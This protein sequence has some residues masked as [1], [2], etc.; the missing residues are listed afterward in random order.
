LQAAYEL[1]TYEKAKK[2][3]GT[4]RKELRLLNE[5][6]MASLD[7]GFEETLTLHK[8][9]LFD[10]IGKSFKTTNAIENG[11]KQLGYHT[12]RVDRWQNSNQR[13]RWIATALM[14]IEP[15]LKKVKGHKFLSQLRIKMKG[16]N[17]QKKNFTEQ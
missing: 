11:N 7:E 5:S 16:S 4:I 9:G 14:E 3:L 17:S 10:K 8:L 1:L 2:K 6:A 15:R 13:Q 12:D